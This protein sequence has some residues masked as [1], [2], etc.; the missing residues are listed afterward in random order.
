[1]TQTISSRLATTR[2][3]EREH[4]YHLI[5]QDHLRFPAGI[6]VVRILS[7]KAWITHHQRDVTLKSGESVALVVTQKGSVL[8]PLGRHPL[9]LAVARIG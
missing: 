1:M 6:Y 5:G 4:T 9:E 8:S 7:G 3:A 2:E